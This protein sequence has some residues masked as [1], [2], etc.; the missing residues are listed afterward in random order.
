[1]C[2]DSVVGYGLFSLRISPST[3]TSRPF[4]GNSG[5]SLYVA[6][7]YRWRVDRCRNAMPD[8][9]QGRGERRIRTVIVEDEAPARSH[10]GKSVSS[11]GAVACDRS[12]ATLVISP[13]LPC[14]K[15]HAQQ[16]DI[17][18]R[19]GARCCESAARRAMNERLNV[20]GFSSTWAPRT[21]P[22]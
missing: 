11:Y 1:M 21:S 14:E 15:S 17:F 16:D 7:T 19:H 4:E 8:G 18:R 13:A 22:S 5:T 6:W 9:G 3:S 2:R 10:L 12:R 20:R